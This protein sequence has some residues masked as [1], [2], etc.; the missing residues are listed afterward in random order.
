MFADNDSI[1]KSIV[2]DNGKAPCVILYTEQ[3]LEDLKNLCC[4]GQSI[5]EIDK[6]FNLC[7][8]HVTASCYTQTTV[9]MESTR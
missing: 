9:V 6:T 1:V 8:M 3:Q 2:K 4:T 7:D 5:L